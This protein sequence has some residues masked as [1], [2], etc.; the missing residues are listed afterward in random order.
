M[1]TG[2]SLPLS[3]QPAISPCS[4][5]DQSSVY[6]PTQFLKMKLNIILRFTPS[7]PGGP[8]PSVSPQEP[9]MYPSSPPTRATF[10]SHLIRL[11]FI[12]QIVFVGETMHELRHLIFSPTPLLPRPS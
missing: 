2:G 11:D 7:I 10:A 5:P 8:F 1:E 3:Q 4:E 6:L 9:C 12:N